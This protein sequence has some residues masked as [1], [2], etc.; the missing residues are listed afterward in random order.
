[1]TKIN[2]IKE[3]K[4]MFDGCSSLESLPDISKWNANNVTTMNY[5]FYGCKLLKSLPDW[6]NL[7]K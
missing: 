6:Y 3:A 5:M 7:K 2:R 1:M 4:K